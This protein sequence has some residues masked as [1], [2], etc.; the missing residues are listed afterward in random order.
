MKIKTVIGKNFG[1]EGKGLAVNRFASSAYKNGESVLVIRHN[2]GAQAGHTVDLEDGRFIFHQL[3]SGSFAGADTLWSETFLPDL[4][5]VGEE[6]EQF[7]EVSG[8]VPV[9]YADELCR[10]TYIDDILINMAL[11][12]SRGSDR[13]GSCGMG[14]N[15]CV[16]RS[17]EFPLRLGKIRGMTVQELFSELKYIRK[18][19]IPYRLDGL[20]LTFGKSGEYG[21]L[22]QSDDVLWNTSEQ[23]IRNLRKIRI[24]DYKSLGGYENIIFEGAQGLLL[25]EYYLKYEPHLTTSRTGSVNPAQFCR[26]YLKDKETELVYITRTYVTRHGN[27]PL[28]YSGESDVQKY[29]ITDLTNQPNPWQGTMRFAP[30]GSIEEFLEPLMEDIDNVKDIP[31]KISLMITHIDETKGN[32]LTNN[33]EIPINEFM[34]ELSEKG[35]FDK[36]YTSESKYS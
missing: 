20:G 17:A 22:M 33:G 9:V 28:P 16:E 13:H 14:I 36:I 34:K 6:L 30:H 12:V 1:D 23:M 18:N 24:F 8:K 26:R 2:G 15:E 27:G 7:K 25:D 3:S 4:Y 29:D 5:K 32:V 11:E 10:C 35:V 19:Y 31:H 21:E